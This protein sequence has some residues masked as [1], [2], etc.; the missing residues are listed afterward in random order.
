M[1]TG[2]P[3]S[4]TAVA[5]L[6]EWLQPERVLDIGVGGGR[7]GF[8]VREYGHQSWHPRARGDGVEVHG[9]EGHEPYIG[10]LQ[11][12]IYDRLMIGEAL[13]VLQRI[14]SKKKPYDL[15]IAADILEHFDPLDGHLFLRRSLAVADLVVVATPRL[16]FEQESKENALEVHRSHWPERALRRAGATGVLHRGESVVALF[17]HA[18]LSAEYLAACRPPLRERLLPPAILDQAHARR[19]PWRFKARLR[20]KR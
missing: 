2:F 17:G 11:R 15:A 13:D 14:A 10:D 16:F 1:P 8:V 6:V 12:A 3:D 7:M 5:R 19:V 9:I 20:S 18:G 4:L